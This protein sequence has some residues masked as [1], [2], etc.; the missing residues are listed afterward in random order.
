MSIYVLVK[1]FTCDI[2][3]NALIDVQTMSC[4]VIMALITCANV[5]LCFHVQG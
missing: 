5:F 2:I 1:E 4:S 3:M